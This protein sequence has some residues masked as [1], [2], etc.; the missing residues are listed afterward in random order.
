MIY[1]ADTAD[2]YQNRDFPFIK[3]NICD[4]GGIQQFENGS[5]KNHLFF[6]KNCYKNQW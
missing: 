2:E 1:R 4:I 5:W 6:E 3:W